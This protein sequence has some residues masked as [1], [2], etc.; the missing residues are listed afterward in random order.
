MEFRSMGLAKRFLQSRTCSSDSTATTP[1]SVVAQAILHNP[2]EWYSTAAYA[3]ATVETNTPSVTTFREAMQKLEEDS[4]LYAPD[5][6]IVLQLKTAAASSG[7]PP[8]SVLVRYE[9]LALSKVVFWSMRRNLVDHK[10]ELSQK[11]MTQLRRVE[12]IRR[13]LGLLNAAQ[14]KGDV[15]QKQELLMEYYR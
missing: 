15:A 3:L 2:A 6:G 9:D 4:A 1:R 5:G 12:Y 7:K 11:G 13:C 14:G 8:P 10:L